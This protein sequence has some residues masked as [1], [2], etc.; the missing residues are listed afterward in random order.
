V[1]KSAGPPPNLRDS[2]TSLKRCRNCCL[3]AHPVCV[4]YGDWKVEKDQTCDGWELALDDHA[5]KSA[6]SDAAKAAAVKVLQAAAAKLSQLKTVLQ[7][8]HGDSFLQGA[9]DAAA[10][11]GGDVPESLVKLSTAAPESYWN[12]WE[13][14]RGD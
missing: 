9:H 13:P 10:A 3:F 7:S 4:K 14:G 8:L 12:T 1:E 6:A 11:A 5:E 2:E